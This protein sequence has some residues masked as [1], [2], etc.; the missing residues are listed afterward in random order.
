MSN[1]KPNVLLI[2]TGGVG[3]I[4]A[5]G[6]YYVGKANIDVVVRRDYE[7]VKEAGWNI[8]SVDYGEIEHW[9]PHKVYATVEEAAKTG[10][11]YDFIV[12]AT[13]NL[14]D[15]VQVEELSAPVVTLGKT[16][17]VLMQNGFDLGR[18][19]VA[20]Y[21]KNVCISG[22]SHIGSH[23]HNGVITQTQKDKSLISYFENPNLSKEVQ[24]AKTKEFISLYQNE[25]NNC[26][27]FPDAKWYRYRKLVYNASLNT[28]AALTG[29]DTG[30]LQLSGGLE[31]VAIPAMREV[32]A[33]AKADGVE[34]PKDVIN[35]VV[36]S[37]DGDWFEPSMLV[38]VKK[39]NPIELEVILGNLLTVAKELKVA[40]PVLSVVY[41]LLKVVQFRLKEGC[42]M[43]TVPKERPV[44]DKY[45][46]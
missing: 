1:S 34:L 13:K 7:K 27:Y 44:D 35:L 23:N 3:T 29:V 28:I 42:N 15:I 26:T 41:E 46:E 4:V 11:I 14:P 21:P 16:A 36:H 40:T 9:K 10:K 17:V 43:V 24:E 19:F 30:R 18:P 8:H 22:V 39:N 20:K 45:F 2:G 6:I 25:K 5:Y 32:I 37:D 31:A 38:D 33:I 12:I